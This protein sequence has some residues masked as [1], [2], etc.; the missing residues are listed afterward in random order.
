VIEAWFAWWSELLNQNCRPLIED[1]K[2]E[3]GLKGVML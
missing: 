2:A 3:V 1:F